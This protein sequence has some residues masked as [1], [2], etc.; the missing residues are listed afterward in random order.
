MTRTKISGSI[1]ALDLTHLIIFKYFFP[2]H[3]F[4][5]L[6]YLFFFLLL[7]ASISCH[8]ANT[9]WLFSSLKKSFYTMSPSILLSIFPF[10][11]SLFFLSHLYYIL[12][13]NFIKSSY[14]LSLFHHCCCCCFQVASF[15]SDSVRLHRQQPTRLTR[16]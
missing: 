14:K 15:V 11:C 5:F 8:Y 13:Q 3:I 12:Y 6:P 4:T 9:L 2:H 10:L 16:P 1:G 7:L